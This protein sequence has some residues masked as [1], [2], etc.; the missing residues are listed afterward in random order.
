MQIQILASELESDLKD[1]YGLMVGGSALWRELGYTTYDAFRKAKQRG[2]IEVPLFEV[3]N[4]R[5]FFALSKEVAC[6]IAA[7]R[8]ARQQAM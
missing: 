5:G 8:C 2:R 4:R 3:P 1:R 7:Q 6:W